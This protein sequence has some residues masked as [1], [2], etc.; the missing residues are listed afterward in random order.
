[1]QQNADKMYVAF[2]KHVN[3]TDFHFLR[4]VDPDSLKH[5]F[6]LFVIYVDKNFAKTSNC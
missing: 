2:Q 5:P 6:R 4:C 3:D 1:M